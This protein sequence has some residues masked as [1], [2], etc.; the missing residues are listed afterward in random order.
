MSTFYKDLQEQDALKRGSGVSQHINT[1]RW[2]TMD[3][4]MHWE[5][6]Q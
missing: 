3:V 5:V 4:F 2:K 6:L 1:F